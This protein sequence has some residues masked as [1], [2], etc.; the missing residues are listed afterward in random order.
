MFHFHY[1][2]KKLGRSYKSK[3]K[4][5]DVGMKSI[6]EEPELETMKWSRDHVL[7]CTYMRDHDRSFWQTKCY[8]WQTKCY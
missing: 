3:E 5:Y 6:K 2:F 4:S 8:Y 7:T 1:E